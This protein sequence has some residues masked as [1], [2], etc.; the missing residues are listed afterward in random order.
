MRLPSLRLPAFKTSWLL[1]LT[2]IG[3]GLLAAF[4]ASR[5]LSGRMADIEARGKA[6]TVSV[7]VARKDLP[8]GA[9][10]SADNVAVRMVPQEHAH[11]GA[12]LP[13]QFDRIDGQVLAFPLKSGDAVLWS[14]LEPRRPATFS[15][16]VEEGRRAIT[17]PVDD[18]NSMSGMLEP[19]DVID[20]MATLDQQGRKRTFALLQGARVLATG[21]RAIDGAAGGERKHYS[22][23][24]LDV[25]P[26]Q[27]R[28]L[29]SARDSGKLTA[30]LRN[31]RDGIAAA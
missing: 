15:A 14:L 10:L 22:T 19:G 6:R 29:I 4:A 12:I 20:L 17:L 28:E 27:A 9:A 18:I 5:Y 23:V 24:T 3:A 13:E 11:S 16:R 7:V 2:A 31:P 1:L 21:Q 8:K 25:T 30:L 26:E